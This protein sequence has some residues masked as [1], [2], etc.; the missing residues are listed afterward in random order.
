M[1]H[2]E[3]FSGNEIGNIPW[4]L[5]NI[6]VIVNLLILFTTIK[7]PGVKKTINTINI[8]LCC[9]FITYIYTYKSINIYYFKFL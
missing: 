7:I 4:H 1:F 5:G 6:L 9:F 8:I 3:Y 2:W